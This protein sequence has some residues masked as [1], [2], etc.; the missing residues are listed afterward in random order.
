MVKRWLTVLALLAVMPLASAA[1][2]VSDS[3]QVAVR[4]VI[5][6]QL[7]AFQRDDAPGAYSYA[8]PMIQQ[9]FGSA[10]VFLEM[11][12][13]GYA[14][15]YRPREVEFRD[16]IQDSGILIQKVFVVGPDGKPVLALYEM[17]RQPDGSWRIN[18][19]YFA[20]APDQS[21]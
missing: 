6:S 19:C 17:Q 9:K 20:P 14:P 8:S 18:G 16:L 2:Q 4:Q 10:E 12:R 15:V 7:S 3:D 5:E 1:A 21:V 13:T 11:V